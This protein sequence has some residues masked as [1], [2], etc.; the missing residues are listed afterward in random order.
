M[1]AYIIA[2]LCVMGLAVGQ[3]LFK[4]SS[5]ALTATGTLFSWKSAIPLIAAMGIY[6][7]TSI[8]WVW[9]LQK[10]ELGRVYPMMALAFI[11]VPLGSHFMFGERFHPQYFVGLGL[12][13]V[14]IVL[15]IRG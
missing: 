11:F 8:A 15:T 12:I 9:V 10:T 1:T 6:G 14:G 3:L 2:F 13:V 7:V 5:T 4:L